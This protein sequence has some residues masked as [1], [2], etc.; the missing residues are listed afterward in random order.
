MKT[1]TKYSRAGDLR[2]L[3]AKSGFYHGNQN[4]PPKPPTRTIMNGKGYPV[5][6]PGPEDEINC[7]QIAW[8]E[9]KAS[10]K[11]AK[12]PYGYYD[13]EPENYPLKTQPNP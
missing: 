7:Y 3:A 9:G 8:Q 5:K 10:P 1:T 4:Q 12:N 13:G 6:R 11:D 2:R